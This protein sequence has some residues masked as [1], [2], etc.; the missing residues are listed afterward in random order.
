M[1][2]RWFNVFL[3]LYLLGVAAAQTQLVPIPP[4]MCG[5]DLA[6][7][8]TELKIEKYP[9]YLERE[10][11]IGG[12]EL[13]PILRGL[14]VPGQPE[15][16]IPG[17]AQT[18]LARL[19]DQTS[20]HQFE[21]EIQSGHT[22]ILGM[23]KL[24]EVHNEASLTILMNYLIAN[25]LNWRG[26]VIWMGDTGDDPMNHA[27]KG[28]IAMV[29]DPPS[30]QSLFTDP[31]H[32]DPWETWWK[33]TKPP[34]VSLFSETMPDAKSRCL[35]RLGEWGFREAPRELYLSLG[36][37]SIPAL[38]SLTHVGNPVLGD[39]ESPTSP[40]GT[41]RGNAQATLAKA[42][43][44]EELLKIVNELDELN[45]K[46]AVE[47]LGYIANQDAFEA[48]VNAL[49]L[50]TFLPNSDNS[51]VVIAPDGVKTNYRIYEGQ[52]LRKEVLKA[53]SLLAVNPPL[54]QDAPSTDANLETWRRWWK[55]NREKDVLRKVP[56]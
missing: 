22:V 47:K 6:K 24:A 39:K 21:Q 34:H 29:D 48:L 27:L 36:K 15:W 28:I 32:L 50:K 13:I 8:K 7:L 49:S 45:F 30:A 20:L 3:L 41:V 19:G 56:F 5:D 14:S 17:A 37:D 33:T 44:R 11:A 42:G 25:K 51:R 55:T 18:A 35:V 4:P 26:R 16:T 40:V 10:A 2:V 31:A 38:R 46:D 23:D 52:L 43:D 12:E 53:L 54:P 9:E 1:I